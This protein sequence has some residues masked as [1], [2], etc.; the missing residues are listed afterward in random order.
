[1]N[2]STPG[3]LFLTISRVCSNSCPLSRWCY[4]TILFSLTPFFSCLQSFPASESCPVSQLFASGGQSIGASASPSVVPMII[5][6]WSPLGL[7]GLLSLESPRDSQESLQHHNSKTS[8]LWHSTFFMFE[9]LH[10]D[11]TPGKPIDLTIQTF[12]GKVMSLPFNS[13]S[14]GFFLR[15]FFPFI[16]ISWSL[17]TLQY[18]SGFSHT[19]TCLVL[20]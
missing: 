4:L 19:L 6:D 13:L 3:F 8:I 9:L 11:M 12:F 2:C 10:L 15:I 18:C 14:S 17:I 20:S 1:M 7:A 5:Q 16:F